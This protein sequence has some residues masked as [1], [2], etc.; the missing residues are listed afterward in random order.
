MASARQ[1]PSAATWLLAA[2]P[3][4]LPAAAAPVLVGTAMA[5]AA[6]A[7]HALAAACALL[8]A[9]LIQVGTNYANDYQ[10][11]LKGA[12][13]ER[14]K[15]PLRVTQAGLASPSAVKRATII[16]FALAFAAGLY[17]VY[18]GG[19]PILAIGL[20]SILFGAIYTGGKYSLAYLGIADLFVLVFFG[21]V[22]VVGTFYVQAVGTDMALLFLPQAIVA[23]LGPGF[24][25]TAILLA[26]N[27]R[28]VEEDAVA[29]K[30]T[31]VVRL[32]RAAGIW[33][34]VGC[35]VMAAAVPAVLWAWTG[36][37]AWTLLAAA[38]LPLGYYNAGVLRR[39]VE[40]EMIGPVLGKTAAALLTYSVL[41]SVGW[42]LG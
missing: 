38:V 30:R 37:H 31:L 1:P 17:L 12:D 7:F 42:L 27:I 16:A 32:G 28:D 39:S 9:L 3:K 10:D 33:L 18:R 36:A 21:P 26:N 29:G 35:F 13:T 6:G 34:Y 2:R 11:F 5:I 23:G 8:S 25:A 14:R 19:W 4:T 41:F 22:A 24:L 40:Y 20:L 15:G